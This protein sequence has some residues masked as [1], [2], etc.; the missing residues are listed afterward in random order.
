MQKSDIFPRIQ[1]F[2]VYRINTIKSINV[3][4][5]PVSLIPDQLKQAAEHA[6]L[7][8]CSTWHG[9]KLE[10]RNIFDGGVNRAVIGIRARGTAENRKALL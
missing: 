5:G 3:R 9:D 2:V 6:K 4:K 8:G 10:K 1:L 7:N